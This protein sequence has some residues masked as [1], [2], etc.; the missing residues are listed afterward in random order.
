MIE[1][2]RQI[3]AV[4]FNPI[5]VSGMGFLL[6]FTLGILIIDVFRIYRG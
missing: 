2:L 3:I 5:I 1:D 4:I 6:L